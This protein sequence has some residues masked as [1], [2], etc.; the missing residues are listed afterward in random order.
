MK[1]LLII[2]NASCKRN[3]WWDNK[4]IYSKNRLGR[5]GLQPHIYTLN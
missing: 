2:S 5:W 1:V 4:I 3:V